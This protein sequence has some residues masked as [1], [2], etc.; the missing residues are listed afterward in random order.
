MAHPPNLTPTHQTLRKLSLSEIQ[1]SANNPRLLFD[2]EPLEELERSIRAHNVLVPI[3]VYWDAVLQKYRIIDGE[4]RYRCCRLL[5]DEGLAD[6]NLIPANVVD[7]PDPLSRILYMFVI[8]KY[9]EDWQLMPTALALRDIMEELGESSSDTR[10]LKELTGLS[11]MQID[12]CR[13]LLTF[14]KKYQDM[15][16]EEHTRDRIPSNFWIEAYPLLN[17]IEENSGDLGISLSG[18][19]AVIDRLVE[20]YRLGAIKSVI[21]FRRVMD[22]LTLPTTRDAVEEQMHGL[23]EARTALRD[24][25]ENAHLETRSTFDR[26]FRDDKRVIQALEMCATFRTKLASLRLDDTVDRAGLRAELLAVSNSIAGLIERLGV[27]E[28]PSLLD[29]LDED[30]D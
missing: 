29:S 16:L 24:W 28:Q 12:R 2:K 3:T 6:R 21:H 15:S 7:P 9:R 10:R 4:R 30:E 8:H 25:L 27:T 23:A 20:K 5:T 26:L 13:I 22:A 17:Y 18:R 11:A 1:P 19:E 14:P